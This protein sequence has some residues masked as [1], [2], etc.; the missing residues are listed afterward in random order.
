MES[1]TRATE[2]RPRPR[3]ARLRPR[4]S[5]PFH[6]KPIKSQPAF[7]PLPLNT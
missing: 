4:Y 1:G 5:F 7:V 3:G 6:A 2:G